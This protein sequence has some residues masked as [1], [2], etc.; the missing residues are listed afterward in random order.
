M[1]LFA[2]GDRD[3]G[4]A[5]LNEIIRNKSIEDYLKFEALYRYVCCAKTGDFTDKVGEILNYFSRYNL[6]KRWSERL[7]AE[8]K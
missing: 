4:L 1:S 5:A 6:P 2:S 3:G 7:D 8:I